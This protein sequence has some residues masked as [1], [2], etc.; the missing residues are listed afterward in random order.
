M[1]GVSLLAAVISVLLIGCAGKSPQRHLAEK[2]YCEGYA[3]EETVRG[4][5]NASNYQESSMYRV[6]YDTCRHKYVGER[7]F[8]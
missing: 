8:D 4:L 1:K 2:E 3:Q 7:H 5:G 6:L